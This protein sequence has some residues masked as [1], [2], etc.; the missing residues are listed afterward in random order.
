MVGHNNT[1]GCGGQ[2]RLFGRSAEAVAAAGAAS[3]ASPAG[4]AS[5]SSSSPSSSSSMAPAAAASPSACAMAAV[6]MALQRTRALSNASATARQVG[7]AARCSKPCEDTLLLLLLLLV[8]V[9][10][11]AVLSE[12]E[13][14]V[15]DPAPS[16]QKLTRTPAKSAA[17]AGAAIGQPM[18]QQYLWQPMAFC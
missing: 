15:A 14:A 12:A 18:S 4:A 9:V 11:A 5:S 1:H 16:K 6:S 8:V 7:A 13:R 2:R 17:I 3:G 10:T